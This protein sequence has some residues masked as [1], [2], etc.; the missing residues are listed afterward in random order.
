M[1]ILGIDPGTATTGF[2]VIDVQN[3]M[4][5][6]IDFGCIKTEKKLP[7]AERLNLIAKD[8]Y[9]L[10]CEY[11]PEA[12]SI[13][14]I[15]FAKNVKTAL[16]VAQAR[17]VIMQQIKARDIAIHEYSPSEIKIALTGDGNA[18]KLQVQKMIK[19]ILNLATTPKPDD[20]ADA[21]A[22]AICHAQQ[23]QFRASCREYE[24]SVR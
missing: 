19:M 21:L 23:L 1:R 11:N 10:L 14:K 22:T 7:D 2:G 20:A 12:C 6:L 16:S 3:D 18:D 9:T 8:I 13:E 24:K 15:Y 17:G 5:T 4:L